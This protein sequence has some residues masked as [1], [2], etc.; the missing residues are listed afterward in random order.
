MTCVLFVD[1]TN[2]RHDATREG[3]EQQA[4]SIVAGVFHNVIEIVFVN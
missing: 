1:G 3:A 2:A 4:E